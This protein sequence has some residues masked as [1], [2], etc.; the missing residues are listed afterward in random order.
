MINRKIIVFANCAG[1]AREER[2][3]NPQ[4]LGIEIKRA[5]NTGDKIVA[6][7]LSEVLISSEKDEPLTNKI[8]VLKNNNNYF[9]NDI[10][11]FEEGFLGTEKSFKS[12]YYL[13]H[14]N[15]CVHRHPEAFNNKWSGKKAPQRIVNEIKLDRT[16]YQGTAALL[17]NN[18]NDILK[19]EGIQVRPSGLDPLSNINDGP[20]N[21]LGNRDSEPR[22]AIL[23][24]KLKLFDNLHVNLAFCQLE[25]NST[26]ERVTSKKLLDNSI[27]TNHRIEQI[28]IL[29]SKIDP[30]TPAILMGDFNARP[31]SIELDYLREYG[32]LQVLPNDLP[33]ITKTEHL[34]GKEY[35]FNKNNIDRPD[36]ERTEQDQ[37]W[38]YS[39]LKHK[40]LIDHAFVRGLDLETW[41]CE[42]RTIKLSDESINKRISDH[43]PIILTV[44]PKDVKDVKD[45][46][47]DTAALFDI[48]TNATGNAIQ[49]L[50]RYLLEDAQNKK[51]TT[52]TLNV[53]DETLCSWYRK[54]ISEDSSQMETDVE[55]LNSFTSEGFLYAFEER[56]SVLSSEQQFLLS[57][58]LWALRALDKDV[59]KRL[60]K[61]KE[62]YSEEMVGIEYRI[63]QKLEEEI[64]SLQTQGAS[65]NS[66][67]AQIN[68]RNF[69]DIALY[70]A[71]GAAAGAGTLYL[72]YKATTW[73]K[74]NPYEAKKALKTLIG[75]GVV[76]IGGVFAGK[77][78]F[79]WL[80][81]H[82]D[83]LKTDNDSCKVY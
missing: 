1:A 73:A 5:L 69:T 19:P 79:D 16:V 30:D 33:I 81:L 8:E 20:L 4:K 63:S 52:I 24:R 9:I 11:K 65:Y 14:L 68:P 55:V 51:T 3:S 40:I 72:V 78:V 82:K 37:G 62:K 76:G 45:V 31:G 29:C 46:K 42:L 34:W 56:V 57:A 26:D 53:L 61:I 50:G 28:K 35:T 60:D 83:H 54:N 2:N 59:A 15:S 70:A 25:T 23:F 13:S 22:S 17:N 12:K 38:P 67:T 71:A 41:N 49:E 64:R 21:Y 27:G 75:I 10:E 44:W 32:F 74:E 7:G 66:L 48:A 18:S 77:K 43:R 6:I 47:I 39:H 36:Y 58:H 80:K